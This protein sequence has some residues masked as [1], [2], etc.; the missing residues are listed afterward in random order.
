S[1]NE[2]GLIVSNNSTFYG[3]NPQCLLMS[4]ADKIINRDL[5]NNSPETLCLFYN[6]VL[7]DVFNSKLVAS[8]E[9]TSIVRVNKSILFDSLNWIISNIS[10]G[11]PC[12]DL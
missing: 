7:M 2:I 12:K 3:N 1:P 4:G 9:G 6:G 5:R 8:K 10:G 11:T